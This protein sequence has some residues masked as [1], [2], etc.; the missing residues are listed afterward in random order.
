MPGERALLPAGQRLQ[1]ASWKITI[2]AISTHIN[3]FFGQV[4]VRIFYVPIWF[5]MQYIL[6]IPDLYIYKNIIIC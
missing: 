4:P 6:E 2:I 1:I 5:Y 3:H